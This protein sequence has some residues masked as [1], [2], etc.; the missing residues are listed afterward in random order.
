[1]RDKFCTASLSVVAAPDGVLGAKRCIGLGVS[2]IVLLATDTPA[3]NS[4]R[5]D[6]A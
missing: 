3:T 2:A 4:D 6:D 5:T 1:M